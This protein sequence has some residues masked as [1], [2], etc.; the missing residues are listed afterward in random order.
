MYDNKRDPENIV[1]NRLVADANN[2]ETDGASQAIDFLSNG[3]KARASQ[4]AYN[5]DAKEYIYL[6]IAETQQKYSNA[7]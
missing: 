6:A 2:A 1:Q 7:R 3:W 5:T 4:D